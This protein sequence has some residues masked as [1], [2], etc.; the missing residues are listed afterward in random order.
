MLQAWKRRN[1]ACAAHVIGATA[2]ENAMTPLMIVENVVTLLCATS[3]SAFSVW[4]TSSNWGL[5]ALF[6]LLNVNLVRSRQQENAHTAT[7]AEPTM[8]AV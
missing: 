1:A 8:P 2:P 6:L 4:W 5:L 7:R 3:L